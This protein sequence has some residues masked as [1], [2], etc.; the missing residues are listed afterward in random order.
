MIA[1]TRVIT[2]QSIITNVNKSEYVTIG[3]SSFRKIQKPANRPFGSPGKYIIFSLCYFLLFFTNST[4]FLISSISSSE[5][6]S[7]SKCAARVLTL[8]KEDLSSIK[9]DLFI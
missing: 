7:P 3:I 8:G 9:S 2:A 1:N 6:S 5:N 4:K